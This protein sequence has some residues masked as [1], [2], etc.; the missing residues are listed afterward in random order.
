M[1]NCEN[2][3]TEHDGSYGSGRFCSSKCARGFSTKSKRKEINDKVSKSLTNTGK[4]KVQITCINCGLNFM[5]SYTNRKRKCCSK[6]CA[7]VIAGS[8]D[9]KDTSKMGGLREGGG[10]SKVFEYVNKHNQKMF[11]NKDEIKIAKSLDL[12]TF[13]W[14]RNSKGFK[15]LTKKGIERKYFPDFYIEDLNMFLEYKGWVNETLIHKM[16]NAKER[17]NFNLCIV[18]SNDKRYKNLGINLDQFIN[19]PNIIKQSE[20]V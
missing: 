13:T 18:Y 12:S 8:A 2:C 17:N 3:N 9:K 16:N 11:L 4:P 15:Y 7:S 5:V 19:N 6:K 20:V 10:K 14:R 1:M